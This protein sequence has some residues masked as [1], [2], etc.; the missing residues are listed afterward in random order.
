MEY[1]YKIY[2]R[3]LP[4]DLKQQI[5]NMWVEEGVIPKEEAQRR[6][7]EVVLVGFDPNKE[8]CC[9]TT[10]FLQ[11]VKAFKKYFY[12]FRMYIRKKDRGKLKA[13]KSSK[14]T[15]EYLKQ[16]ETISR[17]NMYP[18]SPVGIIA[19]AENAKITQRIMKMEGWEY[20]GKNEFNQDVFYV[21][22]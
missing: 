14:L 3:C 6:V 4:D 21:L 18:L 2:H 22:F 16:Q 7:D 10:V 5:I 13:F 20:Y 15:H 1:T 9:V 12:I 19:T 17:M 8:V 11:Y